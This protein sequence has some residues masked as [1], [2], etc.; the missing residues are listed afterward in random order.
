M[1]FTP[2][3]YHR[4]NPET[5][6][7]G[8]VTGEPNDV[9]HAAQYISLSK[10][11]ELVPVPGEPPRP[12]LFAGAM[13]GSI[14]S[15]PTFAKDFGNLAHCLVLEGEEEVERRYKVVELR[16]WRS[17][18][19]KKHNIAE[20]EACVENDNVLR[21]LTPISEKSKKDDI[22]AYFRA[23]PGREPVDAKVM[24][25]AKAIQDRLLAHP[26]ARELLTALPAHSELVFRAKLQ[27]GFGVQCRCDRFLPEGCDLTGGK[28]IIV[29][30]KTIDKLH[31]WTDTQRK[32][33]YYKA[34]AFYRQSIFATTGYSDQI[35][36]MFI[37]VEK[38]PPYGVMVAQT[39]IF[40]ESFGLEEIEWELAYLASLNGNYKADWGDGGIVHAPLPDWYESKVRAG[41]ERVD[42]LTLVSRAK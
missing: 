17:D 4:E 12:A 38:S 6:Q 42:G 27:S 28:P 7:H 3:P 1:N 13:D 37:V 15:G 14:D 2:A 20:L 35:D 31:N 5:P 21:N 9:Y 29:D 16:D 30:L 32:R 22:L 25:D 23:L 26:D 34:P 8:V 40:A 33:K 36:H 19:D 10:L 39:P 11:N 18:A 41:W 24:Q